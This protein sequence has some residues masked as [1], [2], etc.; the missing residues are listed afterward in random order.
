MFR[1]NKRSELY[2]VNYWYIMENNINKWEDKNDRK[3]LS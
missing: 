2:F 3:T 1:Q